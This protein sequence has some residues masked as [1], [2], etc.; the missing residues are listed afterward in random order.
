MHSASQPKQRR[1]A[2]DAAMETSTHCTMTANCTGTNTDPPLFQPDDS[3]NACISDD[4]DTLDTPVNAYQSSACAVAAVG[5]S[6]CAAQ[7]FPRSVR[8]RQSCASPRRHFR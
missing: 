4:P 2:N 6:D 3:I 8:R 5:K 7:P 1:K